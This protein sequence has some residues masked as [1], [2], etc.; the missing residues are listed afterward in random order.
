MSIIHLGK[1]NL[2]DRDTKT[3]SS[4]VT[5]DGRTIGLFTMVGD[6]PGRFDV[7]SKAK[8]K[9]IQ[10]ATEMALDAGD[11]SLQAHISEIFL[12][13]EARET[14]LRRMKNRLRK[15]TLFATP[16]EKVRVIASPYCERIRSRIKKQYP[17]AVI[18]NTLSED[19]AFR[20]YFVSTS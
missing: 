8:K 19:E 5:Y 14:S 9:D 10:A 17:E 7:D 2:Q 3:R 6:D 20:H 11:P 16:D 15:Q 13:T 4:E 18:L 1:I 12:A